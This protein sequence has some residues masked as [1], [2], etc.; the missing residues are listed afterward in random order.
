MTP[1]KSIVTRCSKNSVLTA[2][3]VPFP[4]TLAFNAALPEALPPVARNS[5]LRCPTMG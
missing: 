4:A 3:Q 2:T 1:M 5:V